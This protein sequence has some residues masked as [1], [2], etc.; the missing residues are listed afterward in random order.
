MLDFD[1]LLEDY[2]TGTG[3]KI[4]DVLEPRAGADIGA[5]EFKDNKVV[6]L[7]QSVLVPHEYTVL[8]ERPGYVRP[9]ERF[10]KTTINGHAWQKVA[11]PP[12][13]ELPIPLHKKI[14]DNRPWWKRLL[15]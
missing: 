6:V 11:P 9:E 10:I 14:N 1:E 15:F 2:K 3:F 5:H 12:P 4:K 7:S 13:P 8:G